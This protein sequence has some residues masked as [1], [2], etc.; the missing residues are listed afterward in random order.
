MSASGEGRAQGSCGG[1][2][3]LGFLGFGVVAVSRLEA[4][5]AVGYGVCGDEVG[6]AA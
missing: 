5:Q 6:G 3:A 4:C 2:V 1:G